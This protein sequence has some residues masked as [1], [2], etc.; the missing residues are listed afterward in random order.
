MTSIARTLSLACLM[1]T[2][3]FSA[4]ART[5]HQ[6][7]DLPAF[8]RAGGA[9]EIGSRILFVSPVKVSGLKQIS[10]RLARTK[11]ASRHRNLS[12]RTEHA[13][14]KSSSS[15]HLLVAST[16]AKTS[17]STVA[18]P[19]FTCLIGKLEAAGYRIDFMGG[20]ASR[21]NASAH[22]TGN[23][24]DINQ[25]GRNVVTRRLP[26]NATEMARDCGLVHGAVWD[27]PDQGHFEMARKYGYIF[28][29]RRT[30]YAQAR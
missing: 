12:A 22:P 11:S 6:Q 5:R 4:E 15:V 3:S 24:L 2:M 16:G 19:H 10:K 17:V 8:D 9:S 29:H 20:Y 7:T 1:A 21:G 23:A 18:R 13:R 27:R 26:P 14:E 30:R 25:T 28:R